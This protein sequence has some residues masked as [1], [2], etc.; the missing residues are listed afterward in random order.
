[1][2]GECL[3]EIVSLDFG[4]FENE[5]ERREFMSHFKQDKILKY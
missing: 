3:S 5:V 2:F 1:M 4:D